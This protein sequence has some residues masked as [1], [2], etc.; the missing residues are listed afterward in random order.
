MTTTTFF[1]TFS[2]AGAEG[3]AN[4]HDKLEDVSTKKN[5][6]DQNKGDTLDEISRVVTSITKLLKTRKNKLAPQIKDLRTI[7]SVAKFLFFC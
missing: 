7:R 3:Y 6:V 1:I 5:A 4:T 2:F